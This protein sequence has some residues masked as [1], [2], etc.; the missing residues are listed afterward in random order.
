MMAY[1]LDTWGWKAW[2]VAPIPFARWWASC[3]S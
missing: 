3:S 1:L 2:Q